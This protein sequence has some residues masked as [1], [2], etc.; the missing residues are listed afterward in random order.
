MYNIQFPKV[1]WKKEFMKHDQRWHSFNN[2]GYFC[3]FYKELI[4]ITCENWKWDEMSFNES[5]QCEM[6]GR[7]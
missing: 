5:R 1:I 6:T 2:L 3:V 4:I 7:R